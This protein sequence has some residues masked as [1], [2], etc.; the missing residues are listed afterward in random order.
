MELWLT[1][2]IFG[3]KTEKI[4]DAETGREALAALAEWKKR[5]D[6][7]AAYKV[8]PYDRVLFGE[9]GAAVD[10]GDY[11]TFALIEGPDAR[12]DVEAALPGAV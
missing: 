4:A 10:F 8:E 11:S 2:G 5:P 9:E 3:E 6:V 12:R 1:K 7:R